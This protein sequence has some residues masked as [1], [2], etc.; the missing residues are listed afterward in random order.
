MKRQV[1][2]KLHRIIAGSPVMT[3]VIKYVFTVV[4]VVDQTSNPG[5]LA[6]AFPHS[7]LIALYLPFGR[8]KVL[9][10]FL[11]SQFRFGNSHTFDY[12]DNIQVSFSINKLAS[13]IYTPFID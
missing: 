4:K 9:N 11:C 3:S 12:N 2:Y 6:A 1:A 7:S 13:S 8:I 5:M 10:V